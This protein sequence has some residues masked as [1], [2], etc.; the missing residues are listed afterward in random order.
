TGK[1]EPASYDGFA[2]CFVETGGGK[3]GFGRGDFYAEPTPQIKLYK[4]NRRWHIGKVLFE[5]N[6]FRRWF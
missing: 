6:W 5:K 3:A 2:E 1:G 4:A